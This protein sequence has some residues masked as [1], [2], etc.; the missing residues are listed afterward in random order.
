MAGH[1]WRELAPN[2]AGYGVWG[3]PKIVL[4]WPEPGPAGLGEGPGLL[5][6]DW[7]IMVFYRLPPGG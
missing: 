5:R 6:A 2:T 1:W 7:G 3:V 4:A